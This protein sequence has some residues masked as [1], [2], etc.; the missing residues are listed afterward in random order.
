MPLEAVAVVRDEFPSRLFTYGDLADDD[1]VALARE[2]DKS[3]LEVLLERYVSYARVKAKT[4]FLVGADREDIIQEG[5][6]GLY[7]AVRDYDASK[8]IS[9]SSF[10]ELCITRQVI[11]AIKGATRRK[12]VPLNS[13]VSLHGHVGDE[14]GERQVI[15]FVSAVRVM[16]PL[17]EVVASEQLA[18]VRSFLA[19]ILSDLEVEVLRLYLEGRSYE[20][21]A[22]RLERRSK[23]IDNALQ[24]IKRKL[25]RFLSARDERLEAEER[26]EREW[27]RP[28]P[29]DLRVGFSFASKAAARNGPSRPVTDAG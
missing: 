8:T 2:G 9:F 24:R 28:R 13:Y 14:E 12:H 29:G 21:I 23:S 5:M 7:K 22:E 17:D 6:L 1:L 3:A 26:G 16:D 15:E 10:A 18:Q 25:E 19:E 20:D 4:Y 27:R 11:S